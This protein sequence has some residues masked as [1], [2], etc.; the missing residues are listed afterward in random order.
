MKTG[1]VSKS[2]IKNLKEG[3]YE[4]ECKSYS[5]YKNLKN[6]GDIPIPNIYPVWKMILKRISLKKGAEIF[7]VGC[8]GGA[9]LIPLALNGYKVTGLDCSKEVLQRCKRFIKSVEK[10]HGSKL[11]IN[12][13][14]A[15][16]GFYS[17]KKEYDMVFSFGVV[18]HFLEFKERIAILKKIHEMVK[19]GGWVVTAVPN[20]IHPKRREMK[21]KG[22]GGYKI[23]EIDYSPEKLQNE[24]RVAGAS[25]IDVVPWDPFGYLGL[26][27]EHFLNQCFVL[28]IRG[29]FRFIQIFLPSTFRQKHSYSLVAFSRK[30]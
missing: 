29:L 6:F 3:G 19:P 27:A 30:T 15:D 16:F 5:D 14:N 20:G 10:Y 7:E 1:D 13:I 2:W 11:N 24:L 12:L 25:K 26:F 23:P 22:L 17:S 28:F 21:Q 9:Q 18:E 4:Y 8:G